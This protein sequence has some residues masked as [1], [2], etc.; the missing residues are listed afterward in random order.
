MKNVMTENLVILYIDSGTFREDYAMVYDEIY[1]QLIVLGLKVTVVLGPKSSEKAR[2]RFSSFFPLLVEDIKSE[3]LMQHGSILR[4]ALAVVKK[5]IPFSLRAP[6]RVRRSL[7]RFAEIYTWLRILKPSLIVSIKFDSCYEFVS[8]ANRSGIPTVAIQHGEGS[9]EALPKRVHEW[10]ASIVLV[11]NEYWKKKYDSIYR[12][13]SR[14]YSINAILWHARYCS[15]TPERSKKIVFFES[16]FNREDL[17][18]ST[19]NV[20]GKERVA[21]KPHPYKLLHGLSLGETCSP[22]MIWEINLWERVPFIGI[23]FGS[24]VTNELIYLS[25]PCISLAQPSDIG[26]SFPKTGSFP[27]SVQVEKIQDLACKLDNDPIFRSRFIRKQR[28]ESS[29]F[30]HETQPAKVIAEFCEGHINHRDN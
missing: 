22:E 26:L 3:T 18:E 27:P 28:L 11:W 15:V 25:V 16:S 20:F 19:I 10:P 23:S 2:K 29:R 13:Q 21:I 4:F 1:K 14:F 7:R 5:E 12:R 6:W 17:I 24:T 30:I 9:L 8:S